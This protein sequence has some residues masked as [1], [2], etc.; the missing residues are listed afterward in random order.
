VT[1]G[2]LLLD[3]LA[4]D[5]REHLAINRELP[6]AP[7]LEEARTLTKLP[8]MVNSKMASELARM[9]TFS[10]VDIVDLLYSLTLFLA[11]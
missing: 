4:A 9:V 1:I 10:L 6:Y 7:S 5:A 11:L 2:I 8:A 3:V